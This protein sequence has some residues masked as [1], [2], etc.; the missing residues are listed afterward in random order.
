MKKGINMILPV[1]ALGGIGL[2]V[3]PPKNL[4]LH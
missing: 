3:A 1:G 2:S 4:I